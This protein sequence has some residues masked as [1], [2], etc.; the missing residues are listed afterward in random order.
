V[1]LPLVIFVSAESGVF[2]YL[3]D[4]LDVENTLQ[5]RSTGSDRDQIIAFGNRWTWS[6]TGTA[7]AATTSTTSAATTLWCAKRSFG[8]S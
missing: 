6:A 1:L 2:R 7:K 3:A 5:G 8:R 4:S